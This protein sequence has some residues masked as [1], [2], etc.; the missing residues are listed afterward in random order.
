MPASIA[1]IGPFVTIGLRWDIFGNVAEVHELAACRLWT[2]SH[3]RPN[4]GSSGSKPA[5]KPKLTAQIP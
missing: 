4:M 1:P 2:Y 3:E 5:Q